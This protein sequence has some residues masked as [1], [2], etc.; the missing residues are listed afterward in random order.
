MRTFGYLLLS[1]MLI[2]GCAPLK[3]KGNTEK[4]MPFLGDIGKHSK[5]LLHS[6]FHKVGSPELKS[7]IAL[8]A[9]AVSFDR[10][11]FK[12]YTEIRSAYGES[13]IATQPDSLIGTLK[14][15]CLE[16][17]DKIGI[18]EALNHD[19][20]T[21]VISY[22]ATD[23]DY[24]LVS[25]IAIMVNEATRKELTT[26]ETLFLMDDANGQII[27]QAIRGTSK[28]YIDLSSEEIF[29]FEVSGFC[30]GETV[31][32]QKRI[33]TLTSNGESCPRGTQRKAYKLDETKDYSKL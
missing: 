3:Q 22:L 7:P 32:G 17:A 8:S 2:I 16:I 1:A 23:T 27:V 9:I 19:S 12:K 30:W 20:N 4:H 25:K 15:V 18:R 33:E 21:A 28:S 29:D 26:A 10:S 11:K 14:Y 13:P 31:Y 24:V 6:Q 5:S